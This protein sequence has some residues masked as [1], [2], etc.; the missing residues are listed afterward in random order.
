MGQVL[1]DLTVTPHRPSPVLRWRRPSE[2]EPAARVELFVVND[3]EEPLSLGRDTPVAFDG[4]GAEQLRAD[5]LWAWHDTPEAW[6]EEQVVLPPAG[7]AV[8]A[9]N[10]RSAAWAVG[11]EHTLSVADQPPQEF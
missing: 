7:L 6:L 11:T 8:L 4:V 10:G 2:V 5:G 9:F 3:T 1:V